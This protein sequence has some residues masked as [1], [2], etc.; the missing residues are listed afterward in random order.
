M[1]SSGR[2]DLPDG[3][4]V[5]RKLGIGQAGRQGDPFSPYFL[6][7]AERTVREPVPVTVPV[8]TR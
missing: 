5:L 6:A 7:N 1:R 8:W 2:F 3:H 4:H